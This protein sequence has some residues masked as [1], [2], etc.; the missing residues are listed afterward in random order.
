MRILPCLS[1]SKSPV[2]SQHI[3]FRVL[4]S[5]LLFHAGHNGSLER[6]SLLLDTSLAVKY[7]GALTLNDLEAQ[8]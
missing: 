6:P 4:A 5:C 8:P 1:F 2:T 7:G 3:Q